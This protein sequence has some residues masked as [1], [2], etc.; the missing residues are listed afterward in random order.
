MGVGGQHHAPAALPP[1]RTPYPLYRRLGG[2]QS[3]SGRV[4]KISP[5]PGFD[6]QTI[7]P[8]PSRY[9]DWAIPAHFYSAKLD[10]YFVLS[11]I[12]YILFYC[13]KGC[14][15]PLGGPVIKQVFGSS[16]KKNSR[17]VKG[18]MMNIGQLSMK[19]ALTSN[20]ARALRAASK[21]RHVTEVWII[22]FMLAWTPI[23]PKY[24]RKF[25]GNIS[26]ILRLHKGLI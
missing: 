21:D 6:P 26:F 1:G 17:R 10:Y 9:T 16:W 22:Q 18:R 11:R 15:F 5:P 2:P 8:A 19:T 12:V 4:R 3:P 24:R 14:H 23:S 7:Q 13:Y 20:I 25:W